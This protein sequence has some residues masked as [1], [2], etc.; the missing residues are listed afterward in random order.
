MAS[1]SGKFNSTR[2]DWT[3]P[4][5]LFAA[6]DAEF[7]FTCD[8]A[9]SEE[10]TLCARY[11]SQEVDGLQQSWSGTC[12]LNPPYGDPK[13]KMVDWIKRADSETKRDFNLTVVM[14]IPARTNTR[15]W[16]RYCMKA[17]EIR[18][19]CGRPRFGDATHGLPQ[20]L[21]LIVFRQHVGETRY[22]SFHLPR[23]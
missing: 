6:L 15:W 23:S 5:P 21:A 18:F 17:A 2:Q 3:T 10:N 13:S 14:F 8:L 16:H 19:I 4:K 20:P 12:W 1:F 22:G 9:A 11:F 7:H